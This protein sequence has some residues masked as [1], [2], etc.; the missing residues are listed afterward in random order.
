ME[1][2]GEEIPL[3]VASCIR[4][5]S[6][7]GLRHQG[8]F[9][10]SGSQLEIL[11]LKEAFERGEDP[12]AGAGDVNEVNAA[13]GC[14]KAYFRELRDPLFPFFMFDQLTEVTQVAKVDFL[15]RFKVQTPLSIEEEGEFGPARA[16]IGKIMLATRVY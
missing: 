2:T 3:V 7:Q 15:P 14:L 4:L 11:A 9:R 16:G 5:L 6:L 10:V 13:A 8:V 1:A 12:L